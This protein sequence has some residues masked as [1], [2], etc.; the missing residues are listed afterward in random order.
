MKTSPTLR[1]RIYYKTDGRCA[2]C[3]KVLDPF[4]GWHI[5]HVIPKAQNGTDEESNLV[6]SCSLCNRKKKDKNIEE[7][8][9]WIYNS[10]MNRIDSIDKFLEWAGNFM[11]EQDHREFLE[12]TEAVRE[13]LYYFWP[14]FL[15]DF[16]DII[17]EEEEAETE[18]TSRGKQRG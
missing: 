14:N 8:R 4:H 2:Y 10:I 17:S 5:E 1:G 6:P 11:T 3:G 9:W 15:Y 13:K 18:P 12:L 16:S 7:F